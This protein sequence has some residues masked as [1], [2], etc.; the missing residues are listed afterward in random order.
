MNMRSGDDAIE[1]SVLQIGEPPGRS[2][3][4]VIVNKGEDAESLFGIVGD[5]LFDESPAHQPSDGLG[6]VGI[7]MPI[8]ITIESFEQIAADRHAESYEGVFH[9]ERSVIFFMSICWYRFNPP[10]RLI[11]ESADRSRGGSFGGPRRS[12][13]EPTI[14]YSIDATGTQA[15][16]CF[17]LATAASMKAI[18]AA[19]SAIPGSS[20][21]LGAFSPRL[22]R[23][24]HSIVRCKF[25]SAS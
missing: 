7:A 9:I 2:S 14:A 16:S 10:D 13:F 8:A 24:V 6:S 15:P 23:I 19:P 20:K 3:R 4:V 12:I 1:V 5:D 18:P 25:A 11:L 22:A 17:E 21:G